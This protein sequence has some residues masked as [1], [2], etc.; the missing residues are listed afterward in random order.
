MDT[1]RILLIV[2]PQIDFISGQ[3][4]VPGATEAMQCLARWID[5][6]HAL[7]DA[8]IVTMDQHPI[9]HCSFAEQGGPWPPHCVRYT[10]GAA[11]FPAVHEALT[12]AVARGQDLLYLEKATEQGQD[13]YSA[14][15]R[16]VPESLRSAQHIYIA[17]LAGD[18]CVAE[19][20]RDLLKAIPCERLERL[21]S[22]IAY[23]HPPQ[24][25]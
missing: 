7:Y 3:L 6:Q 17:G 25:Q 13:E 5:A 2:D 20:E 12:R 8:I 15:S 4:P 14:F 16:H 24:R 18:Y 1:K 11:I 19:T 9:N 23:I 10:E 22:C 21:E